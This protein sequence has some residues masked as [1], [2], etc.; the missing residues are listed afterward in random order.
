MENKTNKSKS[1]K[2]KY[3]NLEY[4]TFKCPNCKYGDSFL[5]CAVPKTCPICDEFWYDVKDKSK[6]EKSK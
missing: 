1:K 2:K 6:K 5:D 3:K 4:R